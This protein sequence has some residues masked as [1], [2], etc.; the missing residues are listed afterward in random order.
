[1][2]FVPLPFVV[3]L[4]LLI[5]LAR[6][7]WRSEGAVSLAFLALIGLCAVQSVLLGLRWGYDNQAVEHVLPIVAATLPSLVYVSFRGLAGNASDR[8]HLPVWLHGLPAGFVA[9]LT[10]LGRGLIDVALIAVFLGYAIALLRLARPGPDALRLARLGSV[11]PAYRALQFVAAVLVLSAIVDGIVALD[12]DLMGGAQA[13]V[14]VATANLLTLCILG[15]AAEVA[16]GSQP[17]SE[18]T[19]PAERTEAPGIE[20][21]SAVIAAID[22]LMQTRKLFRDADLSLE[23]LARK[24]G[25]PARRISMAINRVTGKNISQYVNDRRVA[26]ACERLSQT[27]QPVTTIMFDVGFQTKS[28]FNREFRRVTGTSPSAYRMARGA[29][30]GA[31][32]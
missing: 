31:G 6:L 27:D 1:M 18:S 28:N 15:F 26:E 32:R 17:P 20:D 9:L 11:V 24:A 14:I 30:A 19:G 23:R 10:V 25:L 16:G 29:I 7:A 4:L 22:A 8:R 3:A 12:L 21:D 5:L 13:P 2:P